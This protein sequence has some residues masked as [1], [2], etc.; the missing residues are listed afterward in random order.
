MSTTK[1]FCKEVKHLNSKFNKL[2]GLQLSSDDKSMSPIMKLQR[3]HQQ[4]GGLVAEE[5]EGVVALA[6]TRVVWPEEVEEGDEVI[7]EVVE[8]VVEEET[9][10]N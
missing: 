1:S 9:E 5:E 2:I 10:V 8:R 6:P 4:R 3:E 7:E